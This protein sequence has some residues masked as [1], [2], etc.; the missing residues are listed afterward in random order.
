MLPKFA[1]P[2]VLGLL[3]LTGVAPAPA[4]ADN[5]AGTDAAATGCPVIASSDWKA[6]VNAMPGPDG[7]QLHVSG[8]ITLPTPAYTVTLTPGP[9]DRMAPPM[10]RLI[11]T[12][13]AP[14]GMVAS[15]IETTEVSF[16]LPTQMTQFRAVAIVCGDT[17]LAEISPVDIVQ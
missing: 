13:T 2:A 15:V 10:Q 7:P 5:D 3:A 12:A 6:W 9:A 16:A 14:D 8:Q 11:L 17:L 4:H 1:L